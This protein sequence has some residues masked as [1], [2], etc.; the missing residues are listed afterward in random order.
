VR[1]LAGAGAALLLVLMALFLGPTKL[2]P[3]VFAVGTLYLVM[4]HPGALSTES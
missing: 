3:V 1:P 2:I 4:A